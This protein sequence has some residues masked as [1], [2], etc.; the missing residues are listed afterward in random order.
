MEIRIIPLDLEKEVAEAIASGECGDLQ[1]MAEVAARHPDCMFRRGKVVYDAELI[2][3]A[4]A[5]HI[6]VR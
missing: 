3:A 5:F 4:Y 2:I 6:R 1:V